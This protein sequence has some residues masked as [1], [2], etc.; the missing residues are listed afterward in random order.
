MLKAGTKV[1][2]T[3]GP[4]YG[5]IGIVIDNIHPTPPGCA[6]IKYGPIS[7]SITF[8]DES[9][10]V[11]NDCHKVGTCLSCEALCELIAS[12]WTI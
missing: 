8:C 3:E 4:N 9:I 1:V 5:K 7:Y 6:C 2:Q 10:F 12:R 11:V